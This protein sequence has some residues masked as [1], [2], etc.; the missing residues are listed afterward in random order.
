M[1]K[2]LEISHALTNNVMS[3]EIVETNFSS[4]IDIIKRYLSY[5]GILQGCKDITEYSFFD[6]IEWKKY[7]YSID[8]VAVVRL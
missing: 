6:C 4:D 8:D 7:N 1:L 5:K 3:T 2:R